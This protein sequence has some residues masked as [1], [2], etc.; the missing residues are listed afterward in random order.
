MQNIFQKRERKTKE[1]STERN[2]ISEAISTEAAFTETAPAETVH[3]EAASV[4]ASPDEAVK[5]T[6]IGVVTDCMNLNV[7]KEASVGAEVLAVID[8]LSKV[9]VDMDASTNDFYKVC[10]AAGVEGFGMKKYIAV[11]K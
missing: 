4:E 5:H 11:R 7:R 9:T 6:V 2:Q 3:V 10:T 1:R 8:C